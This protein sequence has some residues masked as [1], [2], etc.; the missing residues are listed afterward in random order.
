MIKCLGCKIV[1]CARCDQCFCDLNRPTDSSTTSSSSDEDDVSTTWGGQPES[2]VS[3]EA[4]APQE[5]AGPSHSAPPGSE[6]QV[7]LSPISLRVRSFHTRYLTR[8][9]PTVLTGA[10]KA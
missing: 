4:D 2:T 5:A 1:K 7:T 10:A 6:E 8:H 9:V 3:A